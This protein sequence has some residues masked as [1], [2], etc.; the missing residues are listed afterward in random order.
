MTNVK[1][2]RVGL[3]VAVILT[4]PPFLQAASARTIQARA[5]APIQYKAYHDGNQ[6][7][8]VAVQGSKPDIHMNGHVTVSYN[9]RLYAVAMKGGV[10]WFIPGVSPAGSGSPQVT[11]R[12]HAPVSGIKQQASSAVGP[13]WLNTALLGAGSMS[14]ALHASASAYLLHGAMWNQRALTAKLDLVLHNIASNPNNPLFNPARGRWNSKSGAKSVERYI[15]RELNAENLPIEAKVSRI[16]K[17]RDVTGLNVGM[18]TSADYVGTP[19]DGYNMAFRPGTSADGMNAVVTRFMNKAAQRFANP[20]ETGKIGAF[21]KLE[22]LDTTNGLIMNSNVSDRIIGALHTMGYSNGLGDMPSLFH[23][24][25]R[26]FLYTTLAF[27]TAQVGVSAMHNNWKGVTA[28]T[29]KTAI[30]IGSF[31]APEMVMT[32]AELVGMS[33]ADGLG[34]LLGAAL[35]AY[36]SYN[37]QS[38]A[39][40]ITHGLFAV[41]GWMSSLFT[42]LLGNEQNNSN[43]VYAPVIYLYPPR[44][45]D[46]HVRLSGQTVLTSSTP[47]YHDGWSVMAR[48]D[49]RLT[50]DHQTY[51][52]L[53][54]EDIVDAHWQLHSGWIVTRRTFAAWANDTLKAYGLNARETAG[55]IAYWQPRIPAGKHVLFAPQPVSIVDRTVQL[56]IDPRPASLLRLW[57]AIKPGAANWRPQTPHIR[58]FIRTGFTAV[59][60]GGILIK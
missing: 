21:T 54:Y 1:T 15:Q 36:I 51:G 58:R 5:P 20:Y 33:M 49:G 37:D 6:Y 52:G 2:A 45:E 31:Y 18:K 13:D 56:H 7:G 17:G 60:W 29:V 25:G 9:N 11:I 28:G 32:A 50:Q 24:V 19:L 57:F 23:A 40:G 26:F 59:E 46:I 43:T 44:P 55:F 42:R 10:G 41:A 48:P 38:F 12:N 35:G 34:I 22:G 4:T 14:E 39:N 8:V 53:Y 16:F 30:D 27:D 47:S 3:A